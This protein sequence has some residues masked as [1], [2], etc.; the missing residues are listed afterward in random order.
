MRYDA[1]RCLDA[2]EAA[3]VV[4]LG[5]SVDPAISAEV[6]A[7]DAALRAAPLT[8]IL[9]TV[10]TYRSLMIHYD[11]LALARAALVAHVEA[12]ER[13][14]QESA[15][16]G[17]RWVI[18]CC[19]APPHGEDLAAAGEALSLSPERIVELH[20]GADFRAYMYGFAPGWC[21]LGGLP[22]ALAVPRRASPRGPTPRGA[23][24]IGGGL[25]LIGADPM[26]T[27][28]Y[29]L[30]RTPERLFAPSRNPSFF[31]EV[32]DALRFEPI[33]EVTFRALEE[34]SARGEMIARREASA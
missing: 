9:E 12:L 8:G 15:A 19:Y 10:P 5:D 24:L 16:P 4:E 22:S 1:P 30:G 18:P 33:D 20:S 13:A 6:L 28:W 26:P 17:V 29:V 14:A 32:G 7:L 11:P 2:G 27:G 31:V 25:S 34:K 3:L 23:V 21:Y